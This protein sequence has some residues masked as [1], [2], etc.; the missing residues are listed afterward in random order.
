M[1]FLAV[2]LAYNTLSVNS[3]VYADDGAKQAA[4]AGFILLAIVLVSAK[5]DT[6]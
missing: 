1:G 6:S 3:F 5:W 2:G 4:A